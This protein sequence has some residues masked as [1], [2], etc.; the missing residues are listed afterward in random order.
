MVIDVAGGERGRKW[1]GTE[2]KPERQRVVV[3]SAPRHRAIDIDA[4]DGNVAVA[5][6]EAAKRCRGQII[7]GADVDGSRNLFRRRDEIGHRVAQSFRIAAE[8]RC[9]VPAELDQRL[10]SVEAEQ[11]LLDPRIKLHRSV[12]C[13]VGRLGRGVAGGKE[14]GERILFAAILGEGRNSGALAGNDEVDAVL[15]RCGEK[16]AVAAVGQEIQ[17]DDANFTR[18]IA[19]KYAVADQHFEDLTSLVDDH[20]VPDSRPWGLGGIEAEV[21]PRKLREC[22]R[23]VGRGERA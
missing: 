21:D 6:A 22:A 3:R 20:R 7:R 12:R 2:T 10:N 13:V 5:S 8:G 9:S 15:A 18:G 17:G 19:D 11:S 1:F 14:F 4:V 23:R 16:G